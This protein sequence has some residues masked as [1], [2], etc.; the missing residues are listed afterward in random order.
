MLASLWFRHGV[1][2]LRNREA[3]A[4]PREV[5]VAVGYRSGFVAAVKPAR[6][7]VPWKLLQESSAHGRFQVRRDKIEDRQSTTAL[8]TVRR[9]QGLL[10]W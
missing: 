2:L 10:M 5:R 9:L 8:R 3:G 4:I 6:D 7:A 1:P